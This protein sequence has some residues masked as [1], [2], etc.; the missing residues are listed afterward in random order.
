MNW[1]TRSPVKDSS[2]IVSCHI[3]CCVSHPRCASL[4]TMAHVSSYACIG[5]RHSAPYGFTEWSHR[6]CEGPGGSW[7]WQGHQGQSKRY[8]MKGTL[9][10]LRRCGK[11]SVWKHVASSRLLQLTLGGGGDT[12]RRWC[13]ARRILFIFLLG[14]LIHEEV[15]R[16]KRG[17]RSARRHGCLDNNSVNYFTFL[18]SYSNSEACLGNAKLMCQSFEFWNTLKIEGGALFVWPACPH[19]PTCRF[20]PLRTHEHMLFLFITCVL[21]LFLVSFFF[22]NIACFLY[23]YR[24]ATQRLWVPR[25]TVTSALYR[26]WWTKKLTRTRRIRWEIE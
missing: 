25:T 12:L 4:C 5:W 15:E 14:H 8:C 6:N 26:S 23:M 19:A 1:S 9:M 10:C 18:V 3:V 16:V 22:L 13:I 20:L 24:M 21:L 7:C 11:E 17:A 2:C